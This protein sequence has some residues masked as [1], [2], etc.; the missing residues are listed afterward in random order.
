M[1]LELNKQKIV[2][3]NYWL[4]VNYERLINLIQKEIRARYKFTL[5]G[6]LWIILTPII[7]ALVI[8]FFLVRVIGL[9]S[10]DVNND[11]LPIII[12]SGLTVWNFLSRTISQTMNTF[13]SNKGLVKN[14]HLPLFLLPL[15]NTIVKFI[16]YLLDTLVLIIIVYL[17]HLQIQI[18][19][20]A[21]I[22]L[23]FC[24]FIFGYALSLIASLFNIFIRDFGHLI[25][26]ILSIWFWSSPIFYPAKLI[27]PNLWFVNL[28]PIVHILASYR[29]IILTNTLDLEKLLKVFGMAAITLLIANIFFMRNKHKVYDVK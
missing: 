1:A 20:L 10:S 22:F 6:W 21:L 26:F 17:L 8:S 7:Q 13:I 9:K 5:L 18:N 11:I 2:Q 15:A 24:I 4:R 27:S 23:S 3:R 28:N 29:Q 25:S 16:D 14:N 19:F 12:L